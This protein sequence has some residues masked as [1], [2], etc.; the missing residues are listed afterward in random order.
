VDGTLERGTRREWTAD[1][2]FLLTVGNA[3]GVEVELNGQP[4]PRL[5]PRGAVIHRLSLPERPATG[6]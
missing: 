2:R 1:K 5:G 3:G 4:M 6:S